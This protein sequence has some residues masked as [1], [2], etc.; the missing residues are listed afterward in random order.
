MS[1]ALRLPV[2]G[3]GYLNVTGPLLASPASGL[4]EIARVAQVV[5]LRRD[6]GWD[7]RALA[8]PNESSLDTFC[9][10]VKHHG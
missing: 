1:R 4:G 3:A 7:Y 2:L 8:V 6:A 5:T 9:G 10:E